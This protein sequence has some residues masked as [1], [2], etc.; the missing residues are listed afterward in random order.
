MRP[1]DRKVYKEIND[2]GISFDEIMEIVDRM[3][4]S[5]LKKSFEDDCLFQTTKYFANNVLNSLLR[6]RLIQKKGNRYF[7]PDKKKDQSRH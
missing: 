4:R 7:K 3:S 6:N 1:I 5:E 2:K